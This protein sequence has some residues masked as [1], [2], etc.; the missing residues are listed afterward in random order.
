MKFTSVLAA[1]AGML[2]AAAAPAQAQT[3]DAF[4][5][6]NGTQGGPNDPTNKFI[7]GTADAANPQNPGTNFTS[8]TNCWITGSLCLQDNS[9]GTV[10]SLP[11][12]YKGGSP[13]LQ[14]NT[15]IVPQD[16][17]LIHPG[18]NALLTYAA[19]VAPTAGVYRIYASFN[20]Q[21]T[22]PT[23]VDIFRIGTTSGGLPLTFS[24]VGSLGAGDTTAT[25]SDFQLVTLG[26]SEAI[27]YG[28][29][30]GGQYFNDS[31]GVSFRVLA[32]VPEPTS[33]AMMIGGF[34]VVG[35]ALRRRRAPALAAA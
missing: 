9:S 5:S 3:Y 17:L 33:W 7:Y 21:D 18:D 13:A 22:N 20:S 14:A 2:L 6:F 8:N 16:R 15:V 1:A 34:G 10:A 11:G 35:G 26:A 28:I 19:F 29:G 27:G 30:N 24:Q 25:F 31:T 23:G 12:V 4:A 32:G